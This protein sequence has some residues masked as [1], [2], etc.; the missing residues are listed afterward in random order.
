MSKSQ[1]KELCSKCGGELEYVGL[2]QDRYHRFDEY[3]CVSCKWPVH[4][5]RDPRIKDEF[6]EIERVSI[7]V[8]RKDAK[9]PSKFDEDSHDVLLCCSNM[10]CNH[11]GIL[12]GLTLGEM[13]SKN[14]THRKYWEFCNGADLTP[15]GKIRTRCDQSFEVTIDIVLKEQP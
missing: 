13:L 14:E 10:R 5:D 6:P 3:R 8:L 9:V 2:Y 12:I 4:I 7:E 1:S 11:P 15:T